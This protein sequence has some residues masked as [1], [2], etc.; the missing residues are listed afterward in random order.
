MPESE[1]M[2]RMDRKEMEGAIETPFGGLL[3]QL[4]K[5]LPTFGATLRYYSG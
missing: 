3:L 2:K 1:R 5:K 4:N